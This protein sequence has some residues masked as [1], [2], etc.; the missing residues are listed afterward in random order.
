MPADEARCR[1][2]AGHDVTWREADGMLA[3]IPILTGS[4]V[5]EIEEY[6]T[7]EGDWIKGRPISGPGGPSCAWPSAT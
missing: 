1:A 2:T 7:R 3:P 6:D 5:A 4:D